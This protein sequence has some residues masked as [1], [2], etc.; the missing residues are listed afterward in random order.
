MPK[1]HSLLR[2]ALSRG[3]FTTA[4]ELL[5]RFRTASAEAFSRNNYDYLLA[6]LLQW[7]GSSA[8]AKGEFQ[9]VIARNSPL[10]GYA[11][12]HQAEIER[13]TGNPK[14]EQKLLQRF[15]SQFRDHLLWE[16]A[17]DRL[18]ESYY[19]SANYQA[20]INSL[21]QLIGSRRDATVMIGEAQ[22]ALGQTEAARTSFESVLSTSSKDDAALSA[23]RG[24]D[25]IDEK[26]KGP[27]LAQTETDVLH[28]ARVYQA[29]RQFA[30]A[31]KHWLVLVR[32]FPESKSRAEVLFQLGQGYF[33]ENQYVEAI[34]WY[35][36]A[37]QEFPQTPE[38]E[39][40][41]YYVGHCYQ[42]LND[43]DHA[44]ARYEEFLKN[45]PRSKFVGY[46]HL[47]A[48]DTLRSAGRPADA[49]K[50]AARTQSGVK[51]AFFV[52]EALFKQ[53]NIHLAQG[54]YAA[55]LA[56]FTALK[57]SKSLNARGLIAS[58]S[59]PEVAFMRGYCLEKL[60]RFKDAIDEYLSLPE[61]RNGAAGYYGLRASERLRALTV[62]AR[63]RALVNA[64][65]DRFLEEARLAHTKGDEDAAKNAATE[66]LRFN[67]SEARHA[68]MLKILRAAYGTLRGYQLPGL[69]V[70]NAGRTVLLDAGA[71]PAS[72]TSHR[73]IAGELL[74]LGLYDEGAAEYAQTQ[75]PAASLAYYCARGNCAHKTIEYS[76]P[77][78]NSLPADY[79][80]ELLPR[81]WAEVFF[82]YPYRYDLTRHAR[83]LGVDP[84]FVLS[85]IRQES[86]YNP[87]VKSYAAA[88]GMM[89][90]IS[91]TADQIAAQLK[92]TDFE[93]DDLYDHDIAIHFGSQ[94]LKNLLGEFGTPQAVA[95]AYNGGED[96]V[97]RWLMRAG[98]PEIDRF[99]IEVLK[100][101]TKDYVF[102]VINYYAAYQKLY[103]EPATA[104]RPSPA[105]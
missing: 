99:V 16:R 58:T 29:N 18:I 14:E 69:A 86:R 76:E 43:P 62:N 27:G 45:Y 61:T 47:N 12:W 67:I 23:V 73:T 39:E 56:D 91:A 37:H 54:N 31:R 74:F 30:E 81:E 42:Y 40:G 7:R 6:R 25:R 84:R 75:P 35:S 100:K 9:K 87:G 66:A 32:N 95:A 15:I 21:R 105:N 90:F 26:G 55:S 103:P 20:A 63:A 79:R 97:R 11:L 2:S 64:R 101:Q 77:I 50:W 65:R 49:L 44:I 68:E 85:I 94:Y 92:M 70:E 17:A 8:E 48:I 38:G 96:S 41:Y 33:Q 4:E 36:Q 34:K 102:K 10:S 98:S 72:D 52:L 3:D 24:L 22:L 82:P 51:G 46:A 57:S 13:A 78:L 28:R 19:K 88:R 80:L 59:A 104:E 93:Q 89:Q 5:R 60:G 83:P 1:Q 53:A 71:T